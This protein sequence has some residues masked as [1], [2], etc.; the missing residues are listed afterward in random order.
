MCHFIK[1]SDIR[2]EGN[3]IIPLNENQIFWSV[4]MPH[5]YDH[6]KTF[7]AARVW[8]NSRTKPAMF[9]QSI[10]A[11]TYMPCSSVFYTFMNSCT[12]QYFRHWTRRSSKWIAEHVQAYLDK[13][14]EQKVNHN[15]ITL[16]RRRTSNRSGNSLQDCPKNTMGLLR[17]SAQCLPF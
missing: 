12:V 4:R 13:E 6:W 9:Q 17:R 2:N 7:S 16:V 5:I 10:V 1:Q 3:I 14:T 11:L 15:P 8:T